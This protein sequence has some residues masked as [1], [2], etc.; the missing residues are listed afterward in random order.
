MAEEATVENKTSDSL[1]VETKLSVEEQVAY[2][3]EHIQKID[4]VSQYTVKQIRQILADQG[5]SNTH[6]SKEA[7]IQAVS[8]CIPTVAVEVSNAGEEKQENGSDSE[9]SDSSS[10]SD[11]EGEFPADLPASWKE[12]FGSVVWVYSFKLWY[13]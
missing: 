6:I 4:N 7:L 2:V 10:D 5:I 3:K 12:R 1:S 8:S 13:V 11:S 9:S